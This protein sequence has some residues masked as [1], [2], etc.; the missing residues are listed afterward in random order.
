MI[1][2]TD[3]ER[4][5]AKEAG[6]RLGIVLEACAKAVRPGVATKE[7]DE[8]AEK[9]IRDAGDEP[10]FLGYRPEGA[11]RKYPATM[12]I[13]VNDEV[14]HG[15]PSESKILKTGDIVKLDLGLAHKHFIVDSALTVNVGKVDTETQKLSDVTA[16]ALEAGIAAAKVGG[17]TGD[18]SHAIEH[19]YRGSGFSIVKILGG[20]GVGSEVHE[21]PYVPNFGHPGTGVELVPGM[22]L[23]LEPIANAGKGTV[24]IAND[25]FT[26][27]AKD[28]SR[29][30]HFEHTV[31][32]E[33]TG[34][35]V[36]TRRPSEVLG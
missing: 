16:L 36:L 29:S 13:S 3:E 8:L 12:C 32:I 23:A 31:L 11:P 25:G 27:C 34:T 14:V 24:Y 7:L 28:G 2:R 17:R 18:I 5:V 19:A 30:A 35:L 6:K 15:I 33:E 26:Y 20:H 21:E 4:A 9:M 10:C 1:V 22:V